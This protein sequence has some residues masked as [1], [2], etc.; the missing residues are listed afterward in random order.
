[1]TA[2]RPLANLWEDNKTAAN[3]MDLLGQLDY[4]GKLSAA[5][6]LATTT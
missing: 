1:M 3:K 4:Y 6:G 2:G 5:I